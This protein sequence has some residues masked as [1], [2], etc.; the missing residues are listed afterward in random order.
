MVTPRPHY[1]R[2]IREGP[3]AGRG[4][5]G[6]EPGDVG[7]LLQVRRGLLFKCT[8]QDADE[9]TFCTGWCVQLLRVNAQ[10]HITVVGEKLLPITFRHEGGFQFLWAAGV[11]L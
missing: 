10:N 3:L 4:F 1:S 5:R 8:A 9:L 11:V 6:N 7:R 2:T